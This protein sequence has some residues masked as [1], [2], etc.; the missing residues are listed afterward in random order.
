MK[1][2]PPGSDASFMVATVSHLRFQKV[3]YLLREGIDVDFAE[4]ELQRHKVVHDNERGFEGLLPR[5]SRI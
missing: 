4:N 1:I 5:C 3:S 2:L